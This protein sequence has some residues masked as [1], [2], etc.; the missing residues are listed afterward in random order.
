MASRSI[1]CGKTLGEQFSKNPVEDLQAAADENNPQRSTMV[2]T[3]MKSIFTSCKALS[4]TPESAQFAR[5]CC[6]SMQILFGLNSVFITIT[7]ENGCNFRIKLLTRP[8]EEV[9]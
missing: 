9:S 1:V 3:L 8:D 6:F 4:D 5:Q 7:P 2:K